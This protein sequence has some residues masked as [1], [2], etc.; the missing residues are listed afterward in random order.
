MRKIVNKR[1]FNSF[2]ALV[3]LTAGVITGATTARAQTR[4]A[5]SA[6]TAPAQDPLTMLPGS[7]AVVTADVRRVLNEALPR[8]LASDA[9]KLAQ[10][11]ADIDRLKTRTGVDLRSIE[12]MALGVRFREAGQATRMETVAI[13]RGTFSADIIVAAGRLAAKDK[14][15]TEK[16]AGK[17]IY[18]FT[19]NEQ[20]RLFGLFN[21][22]LTDLAVSVL[23]AHTLVMGEISRVREA[24]DASA[25]KARVGAEIV[26]LATRTP[27]A[28]IGFGANV[29]AAAMKE[30]VG[31]GLDSDE[32]TKNIASI[33][34]VYGSIGMSG[35]GFDV[36]ATARTENAQAAQGLNDTIAGA[37]EFI[38]PLISQFLRN[39]A[40]AKLVRNTLDSLK[41]TTAGNE[42]QIRLEVA[43]SDLSTLVTGS[44]E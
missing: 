7:D 15:R 30:L 44:E 40:K 41:V 42:L 11:N 18:V 32:I 36:Q 27:N 25:G 20:M 29:P 31:L 13:A 2:I 33:R 26:Q 43:Q 4:G 34:Q 6:A 17:N 24:I 23:D 12:R 16:Y 9:A 22:K 28:L 14:Y 21:M 1:I 39:A 38:S 3:L 10:V 35:N 37:K 8:A 19:L 5:A